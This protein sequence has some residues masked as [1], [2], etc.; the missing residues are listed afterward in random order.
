MVADTIYILSKVRGVRHI[1]KYMPHEVRDLEPVVFMLQ[2]AS[3]ANW[4]TKYVLLLW[5]S[6]IVLVPFDLSSIDSNLFMGIHEEMKCEGLRGSILL[7]LVNLGLGY[8][9]SSTRLRNI[10]A[11]F[12][13]KLLSRPDA[14]ASG[15]L[16]AAIEWSV[17]VVQ[18]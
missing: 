17:V 8:L 16:G 9:R 14:L 7:C 10:G 11:L 6:V 15:V 4:E 2:H 1:I 3:N 13:S 12:L 18:K 5:L